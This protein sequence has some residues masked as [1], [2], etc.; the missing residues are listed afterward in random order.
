MSERRLRLHVLSVRVT[1]AERDAIEGEAKAQDV[2][3]GAYMRGRSLPRR[4]AVN[5]GPTP[6][7]RV[8]ITDVTS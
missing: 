2:S 1:K 7:S 6:A 8:K 3:V 5:A 4:E